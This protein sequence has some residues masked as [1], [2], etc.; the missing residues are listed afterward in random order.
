VAAAAH[1]ARVIVGDLAQTRQWL[2]H[3]RLTRN[4]YP[5]TM[6]QTGTAPAHEL[7]AVVYSRLSRAADGDTIA[8]ER[9]EADAEVFA[10]KNGLSLSQVFR[11]N[12]VSAFKRTRETLADGTL[13]YRNVRPTF[14]RMVDALWGGLAS[15]VICYDLDRLFRDPRDL[16][17]LIDLAEK[18]GVRFHSVTHGDLNLNTGDGRAMARVLAA[19]ARKQSEDTARRVSRANE[20]GAVAGTWHGG[21]R[22]FGYDVVQNTDEQ[23]RRTK[24]SKLVVNEAEA[25]ALRECA[26]RLLAEQSLASVLRWMNQTVRPSRYATPDENTRPM[27]QWKAGLTTSE[28]NEANEGNPEF[29]DYVD[30]MW[31]RRSLHKRLGQPSIAGLRTHRGKVV[32]DAEWPAIL[33]QPTWLALCDLFKTRSN[34]GRLNSLLGGLAVCGSCGAAV[35]STRDIAARGGRR[36]YR[37]QNRGLEALGRKE[38]PHQVNRLAE[39]IETIVEFLVG[40]FATMFARPLGTSTEHTEL[41]EEIAVVQ[42]DIRDV[43]Q[44]LAAHD[45]D[46]VD[47]F[48][49]LKRYR[50]TEKKLNAQRALL[51]RKAATAPTADF[52]MKEFL[53]GSQQARRSLIAALVQSIRLL[54]GQ[55]GLKTFDPSSVEILWVTGQTWTPTLGPALSAAEWASLREHL[56]EWG[57]DKHG[58]CPC[59]Q[60]AA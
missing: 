16:E 34:P 24:G 58:G 55:S 39:P 43:Q 53:A 42:K 26:R 17:D 25:D 15:H 14:Q 18:K 36:R 31:D 28:K 57:M 2:R 4:C 35:T 37:C 13:R 7:S 3:C 8:V 41:D 56:A 60:H 27:W 49:M 50:A 12:N 9:Q 47:G 52:T 44:A 32:G 54:P 20:A 59:P 10:G 22:P 5:I 33:D 45:L 51:V 40:G 6:R 21:R 48:P 29:G 38:C 30:W 11:E 19:M 23:G 1:H 46:S